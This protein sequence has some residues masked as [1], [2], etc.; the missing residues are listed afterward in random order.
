[1]GMSVTLVLMGPKKEAPA[2][3]RNKTHKDLED[4]WVGAFV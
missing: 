3:E 1:M 2:R 4:M